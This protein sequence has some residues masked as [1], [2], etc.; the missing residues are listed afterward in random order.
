MFKI[1][2]VMDFDARLVRALASAQHGNVGKSSPFGELL[3]ELGMI[4]PTYTAAGWKKHLRHFQSP[5]KGTD[6]ERHGLPVLASAMQ[7]F[8][9]GDRAPIDGVNSNMNRAID[10]A[11][12]ARRTGRLERSTLDS[13]S[14]A[15]QTATASSA[16]NILC[17]RIDDA[18]SLLEGAASGN[19]LSGEQRAR[20]IALANRISQATRPISF[21]RSGTRSMSN[22]VATS[23]SSKPISSGVTDGSKGLE[24]TIRDR[25]QY[26]SFPSY[27]D[28]GDESAS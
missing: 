11:R 13:D 22:P 24:K 12:S 5:A 25:G 17:A 6:F 3:T 26:G 15:K 20:A 27:D 18:L 7:A 4:P 10:A 16:A 1:L 21:S 8:L 28:M 2:S 19:H 23:T 9:D 14:K